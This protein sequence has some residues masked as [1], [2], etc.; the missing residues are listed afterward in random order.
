[1]HNIRYSNQAHIDIENAITYI[2]TES[3]KNA[4]AYLS[5]YE[6]KIKLLRLNPYL[7]VECK[8]KLIK[9]DCRILVHENHLVMYQVFEDTK[10]IYLIRILHGSGDYANKINNE[11]LR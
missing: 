7:G 3:K 2:A 5:R 10:E 4:L 9:R 6:E 1:M 11:S 8:N